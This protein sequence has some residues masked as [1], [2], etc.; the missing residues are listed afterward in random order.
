LFQRIRED[1][2]LA[3][4]VYSFMELMED[5]GLFGVFLGVDPAN[6]EKA[7]GLTCRE[8]RR[9]REQGVKKWELESA[10]AQILTSLFLSYESMFDRISRLANNEMY[11]RRQVPVRKVVDAVLKVDLDD[12]R[13]AA[14][15][16][17]DPR[18]YSLVT[19]GPAGSARP[20]LSTIDF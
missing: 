1:A 7:F 14:Q 19:L 2:G 10:K 16:L 5:T 3:Y 12:V 4:T 17:L 6:T 18:R 8:F 20:G 9:V 15:R 11:Y 13:A